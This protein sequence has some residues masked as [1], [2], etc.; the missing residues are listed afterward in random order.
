M[1]LGS[2]EIESG[3]FQPHLPELRPLLA[4]YRR[5]LGRVVDLRGH[6]Y[7]THRLPLFHSEVPDRAESWPD[8]T[9]AAR[10]KLFRSSCVP[11]SA[12]YLMRWHR[13]SASLPPTS[14]ETTWSKVCG[15]LERLF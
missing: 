14:H 11:K 6:R 13:F 2:V 15:C 1:R 9:C 5:C 3:Q 10:S 7:S 4:S 12:A 8:G